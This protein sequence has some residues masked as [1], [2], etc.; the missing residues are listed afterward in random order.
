MLKFWKELAFCFMQSLQFWDLK[1]FG[2]TFKTHLFDFIRKFKIWCSSSLTILDA[3]PDLSFVPELLLVYN[4]LF[5]KII[6]VFE[7]SSQTYELIK[8][9]FYNKLSC[10]AL[11]CSD[12]HLQWDPYLLT[13]LLAYKGQT[14]WYVEGGYGFSFV[15]KHFFSTPS[16]NVQFFQTVPKANTFFL[17]S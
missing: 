16:L 8:V 14:I 1:E 6:C 10:Q 13:F 7:T 5:L 12:S 11:I 3:R 15:I 2:G 17:S 4:H 9:E